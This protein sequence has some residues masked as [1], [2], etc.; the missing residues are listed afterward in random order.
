[1]IEVK[2]VVVV[3]EKEEER[4]YRDARIDDLSL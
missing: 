4:V 2:R 1:M 3:D